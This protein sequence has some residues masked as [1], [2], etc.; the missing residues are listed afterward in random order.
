MKNK[1]FILFLKYA[2]LYLR[3]FCV[4]SISNLSNQFFIVLIFTIKQYTENPTSYYVN[5][6]EVRVFTVI[7]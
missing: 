1:N 5:N 4:K 7:F 3:L 2:N 6:T